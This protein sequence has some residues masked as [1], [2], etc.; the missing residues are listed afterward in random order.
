MLCGSRFDGD[1]IDDDEILNICNTLTLAGLDT[2]RS[3]LGHA[4]LH[5]ATHPDDRRRMLAEP[6]LW[7]SAIEELL[8]LY[9][10]VSNDSRKLATDLDFHGCPMKKGDMAMM[11]LGP[12]CRDPA[13]SASR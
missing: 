10:V 6:T 7:P 5:F 9:A 2:V 8:R 13:S 4:F 12:A 1:F 3:Q 11:A